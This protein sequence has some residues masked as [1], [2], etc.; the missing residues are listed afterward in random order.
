MNPIP[1]LMR[2]AKD[3][4]KSNDQPNADIVLE[5]V[6]DDSLYRWRAVLHGPP[7]TPFAGGK[8]ELELQVPS[9]YPIVPP[10]A[11]F[12]TKVFHPNV[13]FETGEIC[14]D[15]LKST[16]TPAWTLQAVCRAI[17]TLMSHPEATSPLN[18]DA[19]NMIRAD[20]LVAYESVARY[21]AIRDA[22]APSSPW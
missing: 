8:F 4:R 12:R 16:W 7:D 14:L 9:D 22:G 1:R 15:I 10:A 5:P 13:K 18:C 6:S 21:Y 20:D 11:K 17:Q 19:G 3:A 2:E